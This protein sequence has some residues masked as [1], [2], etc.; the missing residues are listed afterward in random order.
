MKNIFYAL[1]LAVSLASPSY[2]Q[3]KPY[4][5]FDIGEKCENVP[6]WVAFSGIPSYYSTAQMRDAAQCSERRG[7]KWILKFGFDSVGDTEVRA[8]Q[9]MAK[10]LDAGL[11]PHIIALQFNEEWYGQAMTGV[12]GPPSFDLMDWIA[13][14]GGEQHRILKSVFNLPVIYVDSW[15]NSNKI[16][17]LDGYRPLPPNTDILGLETYVMNGGK[18][19]THIQPYLD[20]TIATTTQP[21]V[22]I[23]QTF[24]HPKHWGDG[25]SDG[26]S[27]RDGGF[28]KQMMQHPRVI[29]AWLFTWRD[30]DNGIRGAQSMPHVVEW[31]R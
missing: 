1:L 19:E 28:F 7:M 4:G 14:Y 16:Y 5:A 23:A 8:H 2:A 25:L 13:N 17:G 6:S 31:F 21:I 18:W 9:T 29:A 15:V 26:P 12:W 11:L 22:L 30:R 24:R 3:S 10:L 27:E 20:Y